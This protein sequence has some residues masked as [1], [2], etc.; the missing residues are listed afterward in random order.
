[1]AVCSECVSWSTA[2]PSVIAARLRSRFRTDSATRAWL[3]NDSSAITCHCS[4]VD[5]SILV[6]V[7]PAKVAG[8]DVAVVVS[9][10]MPSILPRMGDERA[11]WTGAAIAVVASLLLTTLAAAL[12]S[13]IN[14]PGSR[15]VAPPVLWAFGG[16]IGL[17]L[18]A[19]VAAWLSRK[20]WPGILAA[21]AG[22]VPFLILVIVGY[23]SSDL[24]A[25]DQIVGSLL[26]V[27]VPGLLVAIGFA[28][29]TAWV[30]RLVGG[31]ASRAGTGAGSAAG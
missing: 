10:V 27:V 22:S 8:A 1:M 12:E 11:M 20:A 19:I 16:G 29:V 28:I 17:V 24:R 2:K 3:A 23:N 9:A 15:T 18:G 4:A 31:P 21:F 5:S 13:T 6:K 30:A 26:V 25:E 14:G 7:A